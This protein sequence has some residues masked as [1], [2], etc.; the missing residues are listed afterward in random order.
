MLCEI[1]IYLKCTLLLSEKNISIISKK[2]SSY[3]GSEIMLHNKTYGSQLTKS[4]PLWIV[5]HSA[6]QLDVNAMVGKF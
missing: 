6:V 3:I 1:N 5:E 2:N 4:G